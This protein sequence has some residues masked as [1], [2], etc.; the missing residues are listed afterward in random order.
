MLSF[1]YSVLSLLFKNQDDDDDDD[2]DDDNLLPEEEGKKG[3]NMALFYACIVYNSM[4]MAG[5]A[6]RVMRECYLFFRLG[7][8]RCFLFSFWVRS[9]QNSA[10]A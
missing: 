7:L 2:D 3:C 4:K 10:K 8:L 5:G 9:E 6:A 1:I